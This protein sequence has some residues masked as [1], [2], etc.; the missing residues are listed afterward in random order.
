MVL[1]V[2]LSVPWRSQK[3]GLVSREAADSRRFSFATGKILPLQMKVGAISENFRAKRGFSR[4]NSA[5]KRPV[6]TTSRALASMAP[7]KDKL[8]DAGV[9]I[10]RDL[11]LTKLMLRALY[12]SVSVQWH[13]A[14][15]DDFGAGAKQVNRSFRFLVKDHRK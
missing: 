2:C 5:P 7:N 14:V 15:A 10:A 1:V 11:T 3:D 6:A 12:H 4:L 8:S 13:C 9:G